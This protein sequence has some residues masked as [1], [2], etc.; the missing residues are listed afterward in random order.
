[1]AKQLKYL[2]LFLVAGTLALTACSKKGPE[3]ISFGSDNCANCGMVASDAKFGG[4][5]ITRKGKVFKFDSVE[6]LAGFLDK[7]GTGDE[8]ASLW[9]IDFAHPTQLI[10]ATRAFYLQSERLHSPMGL[11]LSAFGKREA[12]AAMQGR[13]PGTILSWPELLRYVAQ[14]SSQEG[15]CGQ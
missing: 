1:M 9:V 3:P 4:E 6:C 2:A 10:D 7:K 14:R 15:A 13:F 5:L 11:N 12:A 8:V